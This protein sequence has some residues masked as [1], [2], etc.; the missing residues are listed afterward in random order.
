M[1]KDEK[2]RILVLETKFDSMDRKL[3][4]VINKIETYNEACLKINNLE[5]GFEKHSTDN[6][7]EHK[8]FI[9]KNAFITASTLLGVLLIVFTIVQWI[10]G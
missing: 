2:D 5:K 6:I 7:N 8:S 3:D 1:T 9:N 4:T 10:R